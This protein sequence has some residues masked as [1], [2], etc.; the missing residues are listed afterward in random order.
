[1]SLPV[2]FAASVAARGLRFFAIGN[3]V[4]SVWQRHPNI[5]RPLFRVGHHRCGHLCYRGHCAP[6]YALGT[7]SDGTATDV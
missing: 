2:F 7:G 6:S 5:H 1:M 4:A 3:T